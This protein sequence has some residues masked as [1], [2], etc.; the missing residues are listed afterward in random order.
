MSNPPEKRICKRAI[1]VVEGTPED[2]VRVDSLER[3]T[4]FIHDGITYIT[5]YEVVGGIACVKIHG[6]SS[7]LTGTALAS[8]ALVYPKKAKVTIKFT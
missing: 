4:V 3:G 7:F 6:N 5:V 8:S 2:K 1:G